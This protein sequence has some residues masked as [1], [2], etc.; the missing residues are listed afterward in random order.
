M[1]KNKLIAVTQFYLD[2]LIEVGYVLKRCEEYENKDYFKDKKRAFSH[3]VYMCIEIIGVHIPNGKIEKS[4]RWLGCLQTI[5]FVHGEFS[6]KE[7]AD[8]SRPD[9]EK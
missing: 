8:H 6:L 2:H 1:T 7:V 3:I 9:N 4:M 5:L